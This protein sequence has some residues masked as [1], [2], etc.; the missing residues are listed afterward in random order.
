MPSKNIVEEF[1]D[2]KTLAILKLF[3]FDTAEGTNKFYLREIS[4]KAKVPVATTFRILKRLKELEVVEESIIK[5]TKLYLLSNNKNTH[6]L[7]ALLEEKKSIV[8]EFIEVVS[9]LAGV[10]MIV[11]HGEATNEKANILIIGTG[12]DH[13]VAK[14]KVSEIKEKYNFNIIELV[15]EPG[16]FNQMSS[17]GLFPGKKVILWES[18]TPKA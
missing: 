14:D 3:L 2:K 8:E 6:S 17:M 7:A 10:Q 11:M 13:K 12:V 4:K 15:L 5:K 1:F 18:Q 16:Q 9:K